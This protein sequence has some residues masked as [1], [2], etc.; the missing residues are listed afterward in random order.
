MKI[1]SRDF[2]LCWNFCFYCSIYCPRRPACTAGDRFEAH[3]HAVLMCGCPIC[4]FVVVQSLSRVQF[5]I[6]QWTAAPQAS[7]SFTI[8]WS[9][10]TFM[11]IEL[12]I[13]SNPSHP[14]PPSSP[15][16]FSLSQHQSFSVTQLFASGGQSTG[17]SA[18]QTLNALH[19]LT[20]SS[21]TIMLWNGAC[22]HSHFM[23]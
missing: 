23:D 4:S 15:F 19:I 11:S 17:A 9:L 3:L 18:M 2:A 22:Y 21:P 7:L 14:L 1:S 10:L 6:T 5:F 20:C 12:V 16:A 13:L 8:S